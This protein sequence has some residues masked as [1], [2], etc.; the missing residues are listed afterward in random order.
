MFF[1]CVPVGWLEF[2]CPR[3][4]STRLGSKLGSGLLL[5]L[6]PETCTG[7]LLLW[8]KYEDQLE[9]CCVSKSL[10]LKLTHDHFKL[11]YATDKANCMAKLNI[12]VAGKYTLS[13]ESILG[14]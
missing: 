11:A 6:S 8:Q 2:E 10:Y 3:L 12:S 4:G 14:R 9:T 5:S 1:T 13:L 7:H